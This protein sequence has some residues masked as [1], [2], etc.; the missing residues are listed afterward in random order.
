MVAIMMP[1]FLDAYAPP[2][3]RFKGKGRYLPLH[4][5]LSTR[6]CGWAAAPC[7]RLPLAQGPK[8]QVPGLPSAPSKACAKQREAP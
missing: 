5:V 4:V 2:G 3:S 8:S 6:R 1:A 7:A